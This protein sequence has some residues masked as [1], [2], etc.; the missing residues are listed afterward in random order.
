MKLRDIII[1]LIIIN[2]IIKLIVDN[3]YIYLG[4]I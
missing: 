2:N 3:I 1:G 4:Q